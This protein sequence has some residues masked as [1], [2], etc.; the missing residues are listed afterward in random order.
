MDTNR[1]N[2][3]NDL[4]QNYGVYFEL[5]LVTVLALCIIAMKVEWRASEPKINFAAEQEIIQMKD[6]VRTQQKEPLPPPQPPVVPVEVPDSKIIS[7][8]PAFKR[9]W[10]LNDP[11]SIPE[12]PEIENKA[13]SERIFR[14]VQKMPE[15]I[16]KKEFY[17]NYEYPRDCRIAGIQGTVYISFVVTETGTISDAKVIKGIGGGC[18][19]YALNYVI[20][21]AEFRPGRQRGK[22]VS[23]KFTLPI[24]FNL[25]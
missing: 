9:D 20:K 8:D 13:S 4:R 23:V 10:E 19:E 11:Y 24:I 15:L 6:V 18:D 1:K 25:R 7:E 21:N 16:N 22:A 5:G 2:K 12:L 14:A 3:K 17:S